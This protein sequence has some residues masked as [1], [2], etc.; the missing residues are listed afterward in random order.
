M[1]KIT[2]V[3]GLVILQCNISGYT[4]GSV[5]FTSA[6]IS[7]RPD[8]EYN[9]FAYLNLPA[10][11]SSKIKCFGGTDVTACTDYGVQQLSYV[12]DCVVYLAINTTC[13]IPIKTNFSCLIKASDIPT[14]NS[15]TIGKCL[16]ELCALL[17]EV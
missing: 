5:T 17:N 4:N 16:H 1:T 10:S 12:K 2:V 13:G 9:D 6:M 8:V 15:T 7:Q 14:I 11:A 3:L